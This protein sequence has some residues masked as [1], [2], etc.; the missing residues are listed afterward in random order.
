MAPSNEGGPRSPGAG[1][2]VGEG[3]GAVLEAGAAEV[4]SL[5]C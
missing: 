5:S 3:E 4:H 1:M 2:A